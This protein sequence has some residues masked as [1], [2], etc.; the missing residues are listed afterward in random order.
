WAI[1][2]IAG[3][4][5]KDWLR[6]WFLIAA[7]LCS[8]SVILF[9]GY[10]ENYTWVTALGLWTL[11]FSMRAVA[12][13]TSVWVPIALAILGF[14]YHVIALPFVLIAIAAVTMR[15]SRTGKLFGVLTYRQALWFFTLGSLVIVAVVQM[16]NILQHLGLPHPFVP[17]WPEADNKYLAY[18][19][20]H[21]VDV[22]NLSMLIAPLGVMFLIVT[23]VTGRRIAEEPNPQLQL[24][25]LLTLLTCLA[26]FW[27]DPELGA[28]RD[29]DLLSFAGIPLSIWAAYRFSE[30]TAFGSRIAAMIVPVLLIAILSVGPN[31][32]EKMHPDIAVERLDH[33]LWQAPQYQTDYD[34]ANRGLSWGTMLVDQ[35][36][37]E[38]LATKYFCR[39][40]SVVPTSATAWFNLGQVHNAHGRTDSAL[41]CFDRAVQYSADNPRYLLKLAGILNKQGRYTEGLA[42]ISKCEPLEPDNPVVQTNYG[43]AL[44][45]LG[46]D[47]EALVRF[48]KAYALSGGGEEA[49]NLG[50]AYFGL[51][52]SDSACV[53]FQRALDK[54][55]S[56]PR[57]LESLILAQLAS[58]R[59]SEASATLARYRTINPQAQDIGYYRRQLTNPKRP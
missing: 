21:F 1:Y 59:V 5:T 40:L 6:R 31:I 36:K 27:I 12:G 48:Q 58:G 16:S 22:I 25:G 54:G 52:Q 51:G 47:R 37:R 7:T 28:P 50:S 20:A 49:A 17:I 44:Y 38:D 2:G 13:H 56:A 45:R 10:I 9:F 14:G 23:P 32:Y 34:E 42:V 57:V 8:G 26:A 15:H 30:L 19:I 29:W 24:L 4:L 3:L 35:L 39:R 46:R 53:Y 55:S 11:Y 41:V 43:I 33:Q 18:S